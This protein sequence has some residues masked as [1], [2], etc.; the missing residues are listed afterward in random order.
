MQKVIYRKNIVNNFW[1][2]TKVGSY[3][4]MFF[5]LYFNFR[6]FHVFLVKVL[7]ITQLTEIEICTHFTR[8][9]SKVGY[10]SK[11]FFWWLSSNFA[12]FSCKMSVTFD[13]GQDILCLET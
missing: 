9:N 11:T 13:S 7:N 8:K 12:I 5:D 4:K 3:K 10:S 2:E 6:K 1:S